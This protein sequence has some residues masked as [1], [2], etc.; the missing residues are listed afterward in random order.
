[1]QPN[2]SN[3]SS[4]SIHIHSMGPVSLYNRHSHCNNHRLMAFSVASCHSN[5]R[6]LLF[7]VAHDEAA[8]ELFVRINHV[9]REGTRRQ[10][11]ADIVLVSSR[12]TNASILVDRAVNPKKLQL[13]A[14]STGKR[15]PTG[16]MEWKI[17]DVQP[18]KMRA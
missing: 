8:F 7:G 16:G 9:Q 11:M 18:T 2:S 1:M 13:G 4:A 6:M 15:T 12:E 17:V 10:H 3:R 14:S 5:D